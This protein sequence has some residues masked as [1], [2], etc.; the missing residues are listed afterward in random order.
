MDLIK[1]LK[2]HDRKIEVITQSEM[3]ASALVAKQ[4]QFSNQYIATFVLHQ[5]VLNYEP[6]QFKYLLDVWK[7]PLLWQVFN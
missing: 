1:A 5:A 6:L 7:A 3:I 2:K 4:N